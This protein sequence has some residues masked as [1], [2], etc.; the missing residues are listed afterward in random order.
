MAGATVVKDSGTFVE[1]LAK[2]GLF[3][4]D[5]LAA[6]REQAA[7]QPDVK[8][9]ARDLVKDGKLTRWQAAQL[10]HGFYLL[11]VGKY[12]LLDQLG[13][14]ETGRV[15]LA[16]HAQMGR[17]HA[18]KI[19][20]RRQSS[21]PELLKRFL[22]DAQRICGLDHRNL[23]H[24]FDVNQ[25]GD[26]Y[27]LVME[28]VEGEDLA[29]LIAS[30]GP[31]PRAKALDIILQT[32]Q[33]LSHAY[34][35][36]V[37]HGDLKPTNL[38]LDA[39][40]TV[41]IA[42]IGQGR[43]IESP[44]SAPGNEETAEAAAFAATIYRAPEVR[45][46]GAADGA[47]DVYSL[48]NVLCFLL[49]GK[50]AIDADDAPA[51]LGKCREASPD[52]VALVQR[53]LT[54]DPAQRPTLEEVGQE[55]A[56]IAQAPAAAPAAAKTKKPLQAKALPAA[57]EEPASAA[58]SQSDAAGEEAAQD[59]EV[60]SPL[61]GLAG[62]N[63]QAQPRSR[64]GGKPA[65]RPVV[66]KPAP[67][68]TEAAPDFE[69]KT[70]VKETKSRTPLL[71]GAAIGGGV[72]VLGGI[73][74]AVLMNLG[75]GEDVAAKA[76]A[77]AKPAAKKAAAK[78]DEAATEAMLDAILGETNPTTP[79]A[80]A[81]PEPP[82]TPAA[83]VNDTKAPVGPATA[84]AA[85]PA[86]DVKPA[87]PSTKPE[88]ATTEP[89]SPPPAAAPP[90]A[91][92]KPEPKP[93][94][95][96]PP[97]LKTTAAAPP[98]PETP[99]GD[100]AKPAEPAKPAAAPKPADAQLFKGLPAAINLPAL[101]A[102]MNAAMPEA[103]A[104]LEIGPCPPDATAQLR[105]GDGAIRG[106]KLKFELVESNDVGAIGSWQF[107]IQGGASPLPV[108]TLSVQDKK[109]T[110]QWTEAGAKHE[111]AACLGNC[112]LVLTAGTERH[113]LAL[114]EAI[115]GEALLVDFDKPKSEVRW[116]IENLP[117]PRKIVVEVSRL[118]EGFGPYTIKDSPLLTGASDS[119]I[120]WIGAD[121]STQFL[122]IKFTSLVSAKQIK[123]ESA[124][125]IKVGDGTKPLLARTLK[126]LANEIDRTRLG[127]INQEKL[128]DQQKPKDDNQ[129]KIVAAQKE[130]V[131]KQQDALNAQHDSLNQLQQ[132]VAE[133]KD[134]SEVFFR[135][136][137][138][139]DDDA[140]IDLVVTDLN[141]PPKKDEPKPDA[142]AK[143]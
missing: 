95:K 33:G 58:Q 57:D 124:G 9:L 45:G 4:A 46:G 130:L 59:S 81:N 56:A 62:L 127:L 2:S 1:G 32:I 20:S 31:L 118:S 24:Y 67:V 80:E 70:D 12:R 64:T 26:K 10:L 142:K 60:P 36:Q 109:L 136:Y 22:A 110:F 115:Q 86:D 43:L 6:I 78:A 123:V 96:S 8:L 14:G 18:L 114:R 48:G 13:S 38:M 143:K 97:E 108:A 21:R 99:K 79:P 88:P 133:L 85:K 84:D 72:L 75:S 98:P 5:S 16:E 49:A 141:P 71:I 27:Y 83:P 42:D 41:K 94:D 39:S 132:L 55:L 90:T 93:G 129:K 122:G 137:Y 121:E 37:V 120:A 65:V 139:T 117:D 87:E 54:A 50:A 125:Q 7:A 11:V 17:R 19:L 103:L 128:L 111:S 25:D 29:K 35:R 30:R 63:F 40:G 74:A 51:I 73:L 92:P 61:A 140:Q 66:A 106:G 91:E 34:E 77:K 28:Y 53:M 3:T 68:G 89:A 102:E 44:A 82:Q 134:Q 131:K 119:N 69:K 105:G 52:L 126:S 76:V 135:V 116:T 107:E 15:Y 100:A 113:E 101:T 112:Q 138:Q 23:S 47:S 104:A